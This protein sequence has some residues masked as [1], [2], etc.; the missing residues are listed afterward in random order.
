MNGVGTSGILLYLVMGLFQRK[1]RF[2]RT[3]LRETEIL[4][5]EAGK[6]AVPDLL[7][8]IR[9]VSW[10]STV[11]LRR[12]SVKSVHSRL[13]HLSKCFWIY[14][15]QSTIR[16]SLVMKGSGST[17]L[18]SCKRHSELYMQLCLQCTG[19]EFHLYLVVDSGQRNKMSFLRDGRTILGRIA[20]NTSHI[21]S[22]NDTC[23]AKYRVMKLTS[24]S[25]VKD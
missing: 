7:Q 18:R 19:W 23:Q 15:V 5:L 8:I 17:V 24:V 22:T 21:Q 16:I 10:K 14:S 3:H 2:Q 11:S 9:C 20:F 25:K 4:L 6:R 1:E 12:K 13:L